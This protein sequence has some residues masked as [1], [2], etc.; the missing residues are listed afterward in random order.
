MSRVA[1][2]ATGIAVVVTDTVVAFGTEASCKDYK[3]QAEPC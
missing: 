2:A 1:A 3:K